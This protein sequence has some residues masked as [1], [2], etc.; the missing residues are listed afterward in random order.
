MK[1]SPIG[2]YERKN[3]L[4]PIL[5]TMT[6]ESRVRKQAWLRHGCNA[7]DSA[8]QT[9]QPMSFWTEQDVL[10]YIKRFKVPI[11]SVYGDIIRVDAKQR[12]IEPVGDIG[13]FS[14]DGSFVDNFEG[15][16]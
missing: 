5:G 7:F 6:E 3:H 12:P 8:K 2:I 4:K 16:S 13:Y 1:K 15:C 11:A 14:A 10:T 9:S